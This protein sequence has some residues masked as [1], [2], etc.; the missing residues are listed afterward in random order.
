MATLAEYKRKRNFKDTP[1]PGAKIERSKKNRFVIQRHQASRLHYDFRLEM[2][3]VL[4]SWA[5]PKGPSLNPADKRLAVMVEDHP[6]SYID[7]TGIIPEGNYGAGEVEIWDN[8]TYTPVNPKSEPISEKEAMVALKKGNYKFKLDGKHLKGE[9]ALVRLPN[10][11]NWL[12]IKH[13]DEFAVDKEY[14]SENVKPIKTL[15]GIKRVTIQTNKNGAPKK[16]ADPAKKKSTKPEENKEPVKTTRQFTRFKP[17][18]KMDEYIKPMLAS[19][20]D[21]AFDSK[22][23]IFELK[24]DGYRAVAELRKGKVDLYSRNGLSFSERYPQIVEEIKTLKQDCVIDGEIVLMNDE[25]RPDFQKLQDYEQNKNYPL[26]YYVFDILFLNKKDLRDLPLVERKEMLKKLIGEN[27][28]IRY[29]DHIEEK[30]I[31]FFK[32][33]EKNNLEGIM[34]KKADSVYAVGVRT[35]EW[36]KIKN[37]HTREAVIVGY[38]EPKGSRK[39]FGALILGEYKGKNL[40]YIGHTGTGFNYDRLKDL[41]SLMQKYKA[42]ASPFAEK[43]KVNAP[44]E[45]LKP[46]LVCEIKFTEMTRDGILRHPVFLRLRDDKN[47]SEVKPDAAPVKAPAKKVVV[48]KEAVKKETVTA[49]KKTNDKTVSVSNH[50]VELTN[51]NKLYWPDEKITKGELIAFYESISK[52]I[53]PYL[54]D[55]PMSLKR[56]PNGIKDAGFFHKDAGEAAPSWVKTADVYSEST[57]KIIHY[58][59][60]NDTATL[61]YLANLGCI[62]MNPWNSTIKNPDKPTW[63]V[64]D[65]DPGDNNTFEQVIETA[66]AVKT[67]L[68]KAG[69]DCYCKTSGSSGLHVYMPMGARYTYDETKEFAE[70]IATM[71]TEYL[72]D[73]TTVERSL[74]KRDNKIYVDYLQNRKGQTLASAY[75]VR[76]KPGAP[77]SAPLYWKEVKKGLH[78]S[79]FTIN[80]ILKRLEKTGDLFENVLKKGIDLKKCLKNLGA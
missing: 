3:G 42:P 60:C 66:L 45:W 73:L 52:Y 49:P 28:I 80:N 55:R 30:G 35:K 27:E 59:L 32:Q 18:R 48:K 37:N 67:I 21:E 41:W 4:K 62:E 26:I 69:A 51:L 13:R 77:V 64:M 25:N 56:N 23:W 46:N 33:V 1:E 43:I 24:L 50:K 44:V 20:G 75:S 12:L 58:I 22:D 54:K 15:K 36:L 76:P 14:S 40:R 31:E 78:P 10:E 17:G 53:L 79:Q 57:N 47:P 8:G 7:F 63:L 39:H 29:S 71:V 74:S 61:L 9:F 72:P 2:E 65:I 38:T 70:L 19:L 68:D 16:K 11:K 6:V 34:A 5:V